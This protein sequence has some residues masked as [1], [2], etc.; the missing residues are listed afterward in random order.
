VLVLEVFERGGLFEGGP[1]LEE[2]PAERAANNLSTSAD[3]ACLL[4]TS[5]AAERSPPDLP[6]AGDELFLADDEV[7]EPGGTNVVEQGPIARSASTARTDKRGCSVSG[8][9]DGTFV[10]DKGPKY[11]GGLHRSPAGPSDE[12]SGPFDDSSAGLR[13][14]LWRVFFGGLDDG[15]FDDMITKMIFV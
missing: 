14:G 6:D 10:K 11:E 13:G 7:E 5:S 15:E 8:P 12:P 9:T 1:R 4:S 3:A 2:L